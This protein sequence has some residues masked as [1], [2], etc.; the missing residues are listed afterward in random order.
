MSER[1]K[2]ILKRHN[3]NHLKW[4]VVFI[5]LMLSLASNAQE[6]RL[7]VRSIRFQG[8]AFFTDRQLLSVVHL[9]VEE[10]YD[11]DRANADCKDIMEYYQRYGKYHVTVEYPRIEIVDAGWV[12]VFFTIHENAD[13]KAGEVIFR[14]NRLFSDFKLREFTGMPQDQPVSLE[15]LSA[16][17]YQIPSIYGE[18]GFLFAEA[19]LDSIVYIDEGYNAYLGVS[20]G[21]RCYAEKY[22]FEG[23]KVTTEETLLRISRIR[24]VDLLTLSTINRITENLSKK[25]YIRECEIVPT[26]ARTVLFRITEDKM[27]NLTGIVGYNNTGDSGDEFTGYINLDF[28]NL[29]GTDRALSLKWQRYSKSRSYVKL[30]YHESGFGDIPIAADIDFYRQEVDSIYIQ[31]A[32]DL[33]VYYYT[34]YQKF[35][36]YLGVE[37]VYPGSMRPAVVEKT[38]FRKAGVFW[39]YNDVDYERNPSSGD[40]FNIRYYHTF[41]QIEGEYHDYYTTELGWSHYKKLYKRLVLATSINAKEKEKTDLEDYESFEMGGSQSLR[42]FRENQFHGHRLGWINLEVRQLLSRLSRLFVFVDYGYVEFH[43]GDEVERLDDLFGYGLGLRVETAIG[44]LQLDYALSYSQ[45]KWTE[46]QNGFIHFGIDTK[47]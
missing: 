19:W 25:S 16:A 17:I 3:I 18:M 35:G 15:E 28:L 1:S 24:Q 43:N 9:E 20:E 5:F 4:I 22:R 41:Q 46:P 7:R 21:P 36:I 29:F 11:Q 33:E 34:L 42:G 14:G 12:D 13:V 31:S 38:S 32:V 45:G 27:I 47:L 39:N 2:P 8:N 37:D 23:N 6:N 30:G 40:D 44:Q 26:D 10:W